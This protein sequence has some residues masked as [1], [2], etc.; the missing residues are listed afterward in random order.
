MKKFVIPILVLGLS[1][2]ASNPDKL[3]QSYVSPLKYADYTCRQ[4]ASE[5]ETVSSRTVEVY[6]RLKKERTADNWQMGIGLLVLWPTLFLLEG[7]DGVEATEYSRLKGEYEA[8]RQVN[9]QKSCDINF[10]T[11]TDDIIKLEDSRLNQ[12]DKVTGEAL[13][14]VKPDEIEL[15]RGRAN[16]GDPSAQYDLGVM[17]MNGQ[18]TSKNNIEA[19]GWFRMA[20]EQGYDL[21][22]YSLGFMYGNG[23]GVPRDLIITYMWWSLAAANGNETAKKDILEVEKI[24]TQMQII[25]AQDM[26]REWIKKY[27]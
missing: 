22:Q 10:L 12:T 15:V 13:K 18:G 8:L 16:S 23:A 26:T 3:G 24:M 11:S 2:C 25:E 1:A 14:L 5:Q 4:L 19:L 7:G 27:Q 9:L 17:L 21:A 6:N 20:A